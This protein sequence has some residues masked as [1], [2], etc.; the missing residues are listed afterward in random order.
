MR[1]ESIQALRAVAATLVVIFHAATNVWPGPSEASFGWL[2]SG[3]DVFFVISGIVMWVSTDGRGIGPLDFYRHRIRR[4]VPL[5]WLMTTLVL[6]IGLLTPYLMRS[7][8]LE[9]P[10]VLASYFFLPW[11]SPADGA[12]GETWPLLVVGWSLNQEM[13]F[14]ALFGL[15]LAV[16]TG[17][18]IWLAPTLFVAIAVLGELVHPTSPMLHFWASYRMAEFAV[19]MLIGVALTRTRGWLPLAPSLLA[20]AA[21]AAL[22]PVSS[23]TYTGDAVANA[24]LLVGSTL[25]AVG[26]VGVERAGALPSQ[27]WIG[28]LGDASYSLYLV[29]P[30]LI[31]ALT[32]IAER[33]GLGIR[34]AAG[35][36]F[37]VAMTAIALAAGLAVHRWIERPLTRWVT[38]PRGVRPV[39]VG[40]A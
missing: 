5:Y 1:L 33:A 24:T 18:R 12:G 10:H 19:G 23:L 3:V 30:L 31:S 21:G 8:R 20:L 4:I 34:G 38:P 27:R 7:T 2:S 11:P 22:L 28:A 17:L 9:V 13:F 36:V 25:L 29:H 26:A 40:P 15:L 39:P 6:A 35:P 37:V 14:Y 32:S 16:P